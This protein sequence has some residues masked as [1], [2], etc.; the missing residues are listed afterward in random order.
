MTE[1]E[2]YFKQ[3]HEKFLQ[4][5]SQSIWNGE[6]IRQIYPKKELIC[7]V[8]LSEELFYLWNDD[9][10]KRALAYIR[11]AY[12][13]TDEEDLRKV[14]EKYSDMVTEIYG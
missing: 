12:P 9:A 10:V 7:H 11:D 8:M 6:Q 1:G 5:R 13:N 14:Y 2:K 3:Q 4:L